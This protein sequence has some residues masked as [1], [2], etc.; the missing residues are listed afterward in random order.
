MT[1]TTEQ[2]LEGLLP[3][4]G[5]YFSGEQ[6]TKGFRNRAHRDISSLAEY[7][8]SVSDEGRDA[9]MALAR[10]AE[11]SYTDDNGKFRQRT[12]HNSVELR[13][14][15]VDVDVGEDKDYTTKTEAAQALKQFL[16]STQLSKPTHIVSSGGGLHVYWSLDKDLPKATWLRFATLLKRLCVATEFH[17]DYEC[18]TDSARVLRPIGT[19]NYKYTAEGTPVELGR[20]QPNPIGYKAFGEKLLT[21]CHQ[22]EVDTD[23]TSA[24]DHQTIE[25]PDWLRDGNYQTDIPRGAFGE[26]VGYTDPDAH[27][28]A[29]GCQMLGRMRDTKGADQSYLEWFYCLTLLQKTKQGDAIC[30]EWSEGYDKFDPEELEAKLAEVR[31]GKPVL[32]ETV[33]ADLPDVCKGCP[34]TCNSAISLGF[35][36]ITTP[37]QVID[38][39]TGE[40]EAIP[41]D[42]ALRGEFEWT[43]KSGLQRQVRVAIS[44]DSE[45]TELTWKK[46]CQL[47]PLPRFIWSDDDGDKFVRMDVRRRVGVYETADIS[48]ASIGQGGAPMAKELASKAVLML[49]NRK[50]MEHYM[51]TWVDNTLQTTDLGKLA[52]WMGWQ[53]DGSFLLGDV[54]YHRDGTKSVPAVSGQLLKAVEDTKPRGSLE[55]YVEI[56]NEL[57]NRENRVHFQVAWMASLASPLLYLE[58]ASPVGLVMSLSSPISGIGKTSVA[59]MGMSIWGDPTEG[60]GTLG[61]RQ[62]TEHAMYVTAGMR[63]NLPMLIDETTD[64]STDA[65]AKFLY[66][67]SMGQPKAQGSADGGL[68]NNNHLRWYNVCYLTTNRSGSDDLIAAGGNAEP[69]IMRLFEVPFPDIRGDLPE[70]EM[71]HSQLI[72][73]ASKQHSGQVGAAFIEAIIQYADKMPGAIE[74][75]GQWLQE[76]TGVNNAGRYWIKLGACLLVAFAIGKNIGLHDFDSKPFT[77]KVIRLV[78][79]MNVRARNAVPSAEDALSLYLSEKHA[80]LI[81]TK[82]LGS[83]KQPVPFAA[84]Y[85]APRNDVVGRVVSEGDDAGLYLSRA[86]F[87][88]WCG[89][90]SMP[91]QQVM[92]ELKDKGLLVDS[93]LRFYLG[94]GTPVPAGQ[95]R[96]IHLAYRVLSGGLGAVPT[97]AA[98]D[99]EAVESE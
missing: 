21:A 63:R 52:R 72:K 62:S 28:M 48:M 64:W 96:C 90:K 27:K 67:Y 47:L 82:Q 43:P 23:T 80:G 12:Q 3:E 74:K 17:I 97:P 11:A 77:D 37:T 31:D 8:Q 57:Y 9:Y 38:E 4:R 54:L 24:P 69:K 39:E 30:R 13:C 94:R 35:P 93:N 49:D 7:V 40:A 5:W 65:M 18:T 6:L 59:H 99:H 88:R 50:H 91:Y 86:P 45:E 75:K 26:G 53:K 15:W 33:R 55:R 68:R 32:C 36:E 16:D 71:L 73:E 70:K 78:R 19:R 46:V 89:E 79:E 56:I 60:E 85:A 61:A 81:V 44:D 76:Q 58:Q 98:Q 20:G 87:R 25:R 42:D 83:S 95:V 2:F 41:L 92:Q 29:D 14:L 22:L 34:R 66:S 51:K 84:G 10:F 1:I